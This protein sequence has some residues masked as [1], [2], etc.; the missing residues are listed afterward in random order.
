MNRSI[1]V[2]AVIAVGV[3]GWIAS[4][5]LDKFGLEKSAIANIN[6][7]AAESTDKHAADPMPV[8][9]IKKLQ[10]TRVTV[11]MMTSLPRTQQVTVRGKTEALRRVDIKAETDARII[12]TYVERGQQIKKGAVIARFAVKDRK[13]RLAEA[14][15]L[16]RQR[17]IEYNAASSLNKKGFS[18]N[19]KLASAQALLDSAHAQVK[20]M[21]IRLEDLVLRAP[22]DGVIEDRQGEVGD[23][24]KVGN[25]V[26]TIVDED[27]FLVTA[28]ISELDVGKIAVGDPGIATLVT[29]ETIEGKIRFIGK[30][31]DAAT[32]TFRVEL[33]VR[34]KDYAL[35]DG[36][37]SKITF[38]TKTVM[39][40]FMSAAYL[41]LNEAGILGVR[42][43]NDEN[44]VRFYPV[45]V[46][47]DNADG[48]WV[49]GLPEIAGV[50]T[51][52][53]DFVRHGDLVAPGVTAVGASE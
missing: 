27:P 12:K 16:V 36:M 35:R 2:A 48:V 40:H 29:G 6:S 34:N 4:G 10:P 31:A 15:A 51:V 53:Q 20:S 41:T 30:T 38:S 49:G 47:A 44:R 46:F 13:A 21:K 11:Q 42:T 5:N 45:K 3:T 25:V 18:S 14:E 43:V 33:E 17:Q 37:T 7:S 1:V 52:G 32:R 9:T 50:I 22:F 23:Y 28:Q 24:L 39:A 26:A 8:R 19:T